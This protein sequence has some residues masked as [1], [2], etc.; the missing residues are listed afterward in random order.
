MLLN[1]G[2]LDGVRI[3]SP[4]TVAYMA[5]DHL[6]SIG[7]LPGMGFGLGFAVMED[8]VVAG[9][10]GSVGTYSWAGYASTYF[11]VDPKE[12]MVVIAM[13]QHVDVSV[14]AA[15]EIRSQLPALVYS[16]LLN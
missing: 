15:G 9:Y 2:E 3:L 6:G 10:P 8:P 12:D 13:T 7:K 14:P 16:A 5:R 4:R 1:G 11:W